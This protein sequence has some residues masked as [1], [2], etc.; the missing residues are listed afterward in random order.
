MDLLPELFLRSGYHLEKWDHKMSTVRKQS[1]EAGV[2]RSGVPPARVSPVEYQV[3]FQS[4]TI[5]YIINWV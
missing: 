3:G 1:A 5:H 2:G 4:W